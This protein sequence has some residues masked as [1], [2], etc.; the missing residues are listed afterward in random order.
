MEN[1]RE[2]GIKHLHYLDSDTPTQ[3]NC[4]PPTKDTLVLTPMSPIKVEYREESCKVEHGDDLHEY[5]EHAG[6]QY[7]C[8]ILVLCPNRNEI[9]E[10]YE[11]RL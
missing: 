9:Y 11:S 6:M 3:V 2:I 8:P 5:V 1:P 7:L 10:R 4:K